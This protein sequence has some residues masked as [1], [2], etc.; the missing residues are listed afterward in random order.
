MDRYLIINADDF[1]MCR[2]SNL[3]VM[4]L[5]TDPYSALTSSTVMPPCAWAPEACHF[6]AAH[7]DLGIGVH[8]TFTSEWTKYRWA[9]VNA[10]HTDSLR[11]PDGFM[12]KESNQVELHADLD[13]V[14]G[15][16]RAQIER[17]KRLGMTKPSHLDNHM[18]SLCGVETGRFELL[19]ATL[20]LAGEYSLPFRFPSTFLDS[21]LENS[22]LGISVDAELFRKE[23]GNIIEFTRTRGIAIPDYLIPNEWTPLQEVSY[24]AF[25]EYVYDLYAKIPD[26]IT[27]TY[28]HPCLETDDLRGTSRV[29]QR[30]TWEY[31]LLKDPKTRQHIESL[32]IHLIN[33]RDLAAMRRE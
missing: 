33:Y 19:H 24:E 3:A 4:D 16:I 9:P 10:A 8:L 31:R 7:P 18:G 1:G 23:F 14:R 5:L 32:G 13:E 17:C 27:E 15:E 6:A 22:M 20:D 25:Q 28:M 21:Y 30:R 11:D 29:W 26:G 12:W 2:G